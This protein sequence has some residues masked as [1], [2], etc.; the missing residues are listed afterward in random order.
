MIR[1]DEHVFDLNA[2]QYAEGYEVM[3]QGHNI[4]FNLCGT[5]KHDRHYC[6]YNGAR[7]WLGTVSLIDA[8]HIDF[9]YD[10]D[11]HGPQPHPHPETDYYACASGGKHDDLSAV[12]MKDEDDPLAGVVYQFSGGDAIGMGECYQ[13]A[14][15]TRIHVLCNCQIPLD[16]PAKMVQKT[17]RIMQAPAVDVEHPCG[18]YDIQM[19][20]EAGCP[21]G[22][23]AENP[24][25]AV[26]Q[27]A[28]LADN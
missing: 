16:T 27:L 28:V 4:I 8:Q 18:F 9:G 17:V 11:H 7:S 19:E 2:L 3:Y 12:W 20:S 10:P 21:I 22:A 26:P 13:E 5:V 6:K 15:Y 23:C 24:A 25:I 14:R 1:H